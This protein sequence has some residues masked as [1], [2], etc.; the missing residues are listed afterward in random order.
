MSTKII[1]G[2]R[3]VSDSVSVGARG[4]GLTTSIRREQSRPTMNADPPNQFLRPS[5]LQRQLDTTNESKHRAPSVS[6]SHL[7]MMANPIKL[8]PVTLDDYN[9]ED[10]Y[11]ND[12]INNDNEDDEDE[13]VEEEDDEEDDP[14][15]QAAAA[16]NRVQPNANFG[17]DSTDNR[18]DTGFGDNMHQ[19]QRYQ[20][21]D[22]QNQRYQPNDDY[23]SN[24]S[25]QETIKQSKERVR[26]IAK[27]RRKNAKLP[28]DQQVHINVDAPLDQL[29]QQTQGVKYESQAKMS[30]LVMKRITMFLSKFVENIAERYP[31]YCSNMDGWSESIY[32]SLDQYDELLYDIY[33]EYGDNLQSNPLVMYIFALG[34]NAVMFAVTKQI[35][36]NPIAS[37]MLGNFANMMQKKQTKTHTKHTVPPTTEGPTA[38]MSLAHAPSVDDPMSSLASMLSNDG[39]GGNMF[40]NLDMNKLLSGIGDLIGQSHNTSDL[41][42]D[43][44]GTPIPDGKLGARPNV[45]E[46][47]A[48]SL[49]DTEDIM[50]ILRQQEDQLQTITESDT[51]DVDITHGRKIKKKSAKRS[52]DRLS[53]GDGSK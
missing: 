15:T 51:R 43:F 4:G 45:N 22:H 10:E 20:R 39:G 13:D 47:E 17:F 19:N 40:A 50:S 16:A 11:E 7:N 33:D 24:N 1:L 42:G 34:T 31:Q 5:N 53:F 21:N 6:Q 44:R 2:R 48:M 30:V 12:D 36:N 37:T 14:I 18:S 25:A 38:P 9:E 23:V 49:D 27:L 32:L 52:G 26:L 35:M 41:A 28:R 29:R 8:K 3:G 46:M